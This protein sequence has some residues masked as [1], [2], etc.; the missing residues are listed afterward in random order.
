MPTPTP[1][2]KGRR[3]RARAAK[4]KASAATRSNAPR[5]TLDTGTQCDMM[6]HRFAIPFPD[7]LASTYRRMHDMFVCQI[8]RLPVGTPRTRFT[9]L[10]S[11]AAADILH[12]AG[13]MEMDTIRNRPARCPQTM[14]NPIDCS[15]CDLFRK[16]STS[17]RCSGVDRSWNPYTA[18][19]WFALP[20]GKWAREH[21]GLSVGVNVCCTDFTL[22]TDYAERWCSGDERTWRSLYPIQTGLRPLQGRVSAKA[23][24]R[25]EQVFLTL[26]NEGS[27]S[28]I[29]EYG[30]H[31]GSF[32]SDD[33][34]I[35]EGRDCHIGH[36]FIIL[37]LVA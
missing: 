33:S 30:K 37:A 2:G 16:T 23:V 12:L 14:V 18:C 15:W 1:V 5:P 36:L 25:S 8:A 6:D 29:D 22:I 32:S 21:G 10:T 4:S 9:T 7:M 34:Y 28:D 31:A 20:E 35:A 11:Y 26:K 19:V 27:D 24:A 13:T 17:F 3:A